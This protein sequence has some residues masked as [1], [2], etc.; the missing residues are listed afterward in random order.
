MTVEI[1]WQPVVLNTTHD[2]D[3]M[4]AFVDDRLVAVV[5]R[6]GE[7]HEEFVGWWFVEA[8]F[9]NA[10]RTHI[11]AFK[12]LSEAEAWIAGVYP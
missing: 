4:L 7:L 2:S 8:I 3:A 9:D 1:R 11:D 6:L 12:E 10:R 5:S